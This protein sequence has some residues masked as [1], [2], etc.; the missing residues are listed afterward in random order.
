MDA[1]GEI[2]GRIRGTLPGPLRRVSEAI[3]ALFRGIEG[4]F[5]R[6]VVGLAD[7]P[8]EIGGR[9]RGVRWTVTGE[10]SQAS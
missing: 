4:R 3:K 5:E 7:G 1:Y 8:P 10:G 6:I 9:L 2:G